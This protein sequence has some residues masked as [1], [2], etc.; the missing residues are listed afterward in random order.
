M[1]DTDRKHLIQ[2]IAGNLG[3]VKSAEIKA[4]QRKFL[5]ISSEP[6]ISDAGCS[7]RVRFR[8]PRSLR[9]PRQGHRRATCQAAR[10]CTRK[11]SGAAEDEH[12]PADGCNCVR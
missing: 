9:R 1:S 8:R 11:F 12:W 4:R 3:N 2:N 7:R 6:F 5:I 10:Y